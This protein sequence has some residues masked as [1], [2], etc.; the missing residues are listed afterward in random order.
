MCVTTK[1][2]T[3]PI[4]WVQH[5]IFALACFSTPMLS[6]A[7]TLDDISAWLADIKPSLDLMTGNDDLNTIN[8]QVYNKHSLLYPSVSI[9]DYNFK[10][11]YE[12][13][14]KINRVNLQ[15]RINDQ[16]VIQLFKRTREQ[17]L[18]SI[19]LDTIDQRFQAKHYLGN[20]RFK[21][22]ITPEESEFKFSRRF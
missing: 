13:T 9:D 2:N 7:Q 16:L 21:L 19:I 22:E 3:D 12:K 1:N 18:T 8:W 5:S 6:H 4:N 17:K 15:D 10:I 11:E 20:T 14:T